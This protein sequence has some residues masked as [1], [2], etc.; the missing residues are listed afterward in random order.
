MKNLTILIFL[1]S[2]FTFSQSFPGYHI[3]QFK[4]KTLVVKE[5][6]TQLQ[7]YHLSNFYLFFDTINKS[8]LEYPDKSNPVVKPFQILLNEVP[9][10]DY[11]QMKTIE[12][13]V[14]SIYD[15]K[16]IGNQ[17]EEYAISLFSNETGYIYYRY[18]CKRE[19]MFELEFKDDNMIENDVFCSDVKVKK[20]KYS[21]MI[22]IT[23]PDVKHLSI[24]STIINSDTT[25]SIGVFKKITDVSKVYKGFYIELLDGTIYKW[26]EN[27][28]DIELFSNEFYLM[29]LISITKSDLEKISKTGIKNYRIDIIDHEFTDNQFQLLKKYSECVLNNKGSN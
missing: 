2:N 5:I 18:N 12:F 26:T 20:D 3:D 17:K 4:N 25:F 8:F 23:S 29:S 13:K 10:S 22:T 27:V 16:S 1:F 9:R 28:F 14:I 15:V 21:E 7:Q 11:N 19:G 6:P 24:H